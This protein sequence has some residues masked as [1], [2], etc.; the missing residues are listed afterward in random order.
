MKA[1]GSKG[2]SRGAGGQKEVRPQQAWPFRHRRAGVHAFGSSGQVVYRAVRA[3]WAVS[4]DV[5]A[6]PAFHLELPPSCTV[7]GRNM[8]DRLARRCA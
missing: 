7:L 2:G 3:R 4:R 8:P 1:S 6:S 5:S